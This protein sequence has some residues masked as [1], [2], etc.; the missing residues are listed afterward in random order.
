MDK[1]KTIYLDYAA[2]TPMLLE[3]RKIMEPY[4]SNSFYNP[5]ATYLKGQNIRKDIEKARGRV[6]HWLGARPSNITFTSGGSEANNLA[7]HG[8][9]RRYKGANV[10]IS[11]IEHESVRAPAGKYNSKE[12]AVNKDGRVDTEDLKKKI[13]DKTVLISIMY[14]NNEIG[15]VQPIK[16]VARIVNEERIKRGSKGLPLYLHTDACQAANYLDLHVS[17]LGVD[18]MSLNSGK[19]YGPKQVGALFHKTG[20]QLD[21]LID[22]GGQEQGLRSGTE[23]VPGIIGFSAALDIVQSS[24]NEESKRLAVLREQ[25][26][27][28][29]EKEVPNLIINGSRHYRLPN[30]IHITIPGVDNERL[31]MELDEKGIQAAAGSAC[32]ASA[33]EPS[34]VLKA[35]G[36]SEKDAQSSLRMTIGRNTTQ[37]DITKTINFLKNYRAHS[38]E[39]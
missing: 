38:S 12:I 11:A 16:D 1:N 17:R 27:D 18:L 34:H 36:A 28:Q 15:T 9:M 35:I 39:I 21:P 5:S 29:L 22:G 24:R 19:I 10:L 20:A 13:D 30:N 31:L 2:A 7:I 4:Y 32:Q 8:I 26:I 37:E 23:N 6:A 25:L 3:V 14:A 33:E